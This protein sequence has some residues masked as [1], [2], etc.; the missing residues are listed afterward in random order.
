MVFVPDG[1]EAVDE[2]TATDT[3]IITITEEDEEDED[4][5]AHANTQD[6]SAFSEELQAE[7][8]NLDDRNATDDRL[9]AMFRLSYA[10]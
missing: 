5:S 6:P 7:I 10:S 9:K 1:I 4:I 8:R 2:V 3:A